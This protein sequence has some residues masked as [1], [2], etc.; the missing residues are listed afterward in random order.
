MSL[1]RVFIV[2]DS[3]G[4][5][6]ELVAKAAISQ[7]LNTEQN[8]VL[9]RLLTTYASESLFFA[10]WSALGGSW[11]RKKVIWNGSWRS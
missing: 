10:S 7:Y 3:V 9:K 11:G 8:A 1:L 2:S 4:E 5:T 6:G